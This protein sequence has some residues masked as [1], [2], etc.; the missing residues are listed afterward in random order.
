MYYMYIELKN[1]D[2]RW[3]KCGLNASVHLNT[4]LCKSCALFWRCL[5]FTGRKIWASYPWP[6]AASSVVSCKNTHIITSWSTKNNWY[7][8]RLKS[9]IFSVHWFLYIILLLADS[10]ECAQSQYHWRLKIRA[11]LWTAERENYKSKGIFLLSLSSQYEI[12]NLHFVS[13]IL[14]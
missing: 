10:P 6:A 11:M 7:Q 2:F 8:N 13:S 12:F 3:S 5:V 1:R 9:C 4:S 14:T